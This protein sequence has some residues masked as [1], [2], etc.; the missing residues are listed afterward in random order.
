MNTQ[1]H[2]ITSDPYGRNLG[3]RVLHQGQRLCVEYTP[4]EVGP[5]TVEIMYGGQ[6]VQG[7]PFTANVFDASSVRLL[8]LSSMPMIGHEASFKG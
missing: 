3:S 4:K 2:A 8:D 7:S 1:S 6:H 5:H